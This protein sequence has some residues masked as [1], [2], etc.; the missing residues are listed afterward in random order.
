MIH[1]FK[2]TELKKPM[3]SIG[4]YAI[5]LKNVKIKIKHTSWNFVDV[6]SGFDQGSQS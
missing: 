5:G 1:N 3:I 4:R 2:S 6:A